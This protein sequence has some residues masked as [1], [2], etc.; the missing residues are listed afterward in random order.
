MRSILFLVA[1]ILGSSLPARLQ[2]PPS[3]PDNVRV[4]HEFLTSLYP[5]LSGKGYILTLEA[6]SRFDAPT[7]DRYFALYVGRGPKDAITGYIA[8]YAPN[9]PHS[10]NFSYRSDT[11]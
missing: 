10:A 5:D 1:L 11:S 7:N 3:P 4:A 9:S 2:E 6:N 8:G